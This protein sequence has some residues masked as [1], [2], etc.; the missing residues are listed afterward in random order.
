MNKFTTGSIVYYWSNP[1]RRGVIHGFQKAGLE[2]YAVVHW[3]GPQP[4]QS[5]HPISHLEAATAE[6]GDGVWIP[7]ETHTYIRDDSGDEVEPH[8]VPM[9]AARRWGTSSS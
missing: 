7:D 3:Y 8:W 6:Y 2:T 9:K 4:S 1:T 5:A